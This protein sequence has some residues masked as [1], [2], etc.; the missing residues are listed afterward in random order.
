MIRVGIIGASGYTGVELYRILLGHAQAKVVFATSETYAGKPLS[1]VYPQLKGVG[2]L[3]LVS[4]EAAKDETVDLVF[5]CLPHRASM[6]AVAGYVERDVRVIDLSADFRMDRVEEYERWYGEKHLAP[7]LLPAVYG[8]PEINRAVIANASVVANPGCYPTGALLGLI[9]LAEQRLMDGQ[10]IIVDAKSGISGA[11]RKAELEYLFVE[12]S[13]SVVPYSIGHTHRHIGEM[14]QELAKLLGETVFVV[15]TPQRVPA[16]RGILSTMYVDLKAP[17]DQAALVE[18]Y[19][20]RY[21]G[22][23]FV[24]LVEDYL[25]ETRYVLGTNFCDIGL[26]VVRGSQ[27]VIVV[28]AIDNLVKG[29]GGQ[30]VQNMNI[31]FGLDERMGLL[32]LG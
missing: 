18:L 26:R 8:L 25:P 29:A 7:K 31:M 2:D 16:N 6:A 4:G 23:P 20:R 21:D 3:T 10:R 11:G 22:E 27:T 28:T 24:R 1:E 17:A 5:S 9:P 12:S 30:A 15:F 14:E 19:A 32:G 13:Q